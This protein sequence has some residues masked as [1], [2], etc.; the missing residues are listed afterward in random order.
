MPITTKNSLPFGTRSTVKQSRLWELW[1]AMKA[2]ITHATETQFFTTLTWECGKTL[3]AIFV[4]VILPLHPHSRANL[5]AQSA[6]MQGGTCI[7]NGARFKQ[8]GLHKHFWKDTL[9]CGNMLGNQLCI[10][11]IIRQS[12]K[13][14]TKTN[15]WARWGIWNKNWV[16]LLSFQSQ[17]HHWCTT[18]KNDMNTCFVY[19]QNEQHGT[20]KH[21][22]WQPQFLPPACVQAWR[23]WCLEAQWL[24]PRRGNCGC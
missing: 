8:H 7:K 10:F 14:W 2:R 11:E 4:R 15:C 23:C 24:H 9:R 13:L 17:S 20:E 1:K 22:T 6:A 12:D 3:T 21:L 5:P 19:H 18:M 16:P